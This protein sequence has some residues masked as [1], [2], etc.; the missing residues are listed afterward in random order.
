[1]RAERR[2]AF[3]LRTEDRSTFALTPALSRRER[4]KDKT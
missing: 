4:G 2:A 3:D 1:V